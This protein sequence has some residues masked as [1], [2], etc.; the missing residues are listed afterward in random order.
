MSDCFIECQTDESSAAIQ[1][2]SILMTGTSL[3]IITDRAPLFGSSPVNSGSAVFIIGYRQTTR[4]ES[5]QVSSINGTFLHV[6]HVDVS[7]SSL[8]LFR[9]CVE[10]IGFRYCFDESLG[11][12][13]SVL[14]S[15]GGEGPYSFPAWIG[16]VSRDL[17]ASDGR[18]NFSIDAKYSF[19][20]VL[21]FPFSPTTCFFTDSAPLEHT[22]LAISGKNPNVIAT[23]TVAISVHSVESLRRSPGIVESSRLNLTS[24]GSQGFRDTDVGP[25]KRVS[26][27][28]GLIA[29]GIAGGIAAVSC[30]VLAILVVMRRKTE[31][32]DGSAVEVRTLV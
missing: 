27:N 18:T 29:G 24:S 26:I 10:R 22:A 4:A 17:I 19:V 5:E 8:G 23:F 7:D 12:I 21:S 20:D 31:R 1:A 28:V 13:R 3:S 15:T 16:T 11:P 14:L 6:G 30:C 32:D 2:S 9:F 25:S